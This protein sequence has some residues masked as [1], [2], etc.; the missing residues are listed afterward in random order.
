MKPKTEASQAGPPPVCGNAAPVVCLKNAVPAPEPPESVIPPPAGASDNVTGDV[1]SAL[2]NQG[3]KAAD[4]NKVVFDPAQD[5]DEQFRSAIKQLTP[6]RKVV[7]QPKSIKMIPLAD[8]ATDLQQ[9]IA[10][11]EAK[12]TTADSVIK[13]GLEAFRIEQG[14]NLYEYSELTKQEGTRDFIETVESKWG[15]KKATVYRWIRK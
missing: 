1:R 2:P 7:G 9:K 6:D 4:I 3:Y 15:Y 8:P 10:A 5:F 13:A 12:I 14:G 11:C